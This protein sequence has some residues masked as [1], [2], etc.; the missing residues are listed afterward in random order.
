MEEIVTAYVKKTDNPN[1]GRPKTVNR[2]VRLELRLSESENAL[3]NKC[4]ELSGRTKTDVLVKG[5]A[6]VYKELQKDH[7]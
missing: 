4:T 3:L 6:L 2:T 1:M 5:V 7:K